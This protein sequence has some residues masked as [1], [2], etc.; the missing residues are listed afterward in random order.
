MNEKSYILKKLLAW[1]GNRIRRQIIPTHCDTYHNNH[2][3]AQGT[4]GA[5]EREGPFYIA[6][7]V[8]KVLTEDLTLELNFGG[9]PDR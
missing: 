4:V 9:R 1:W 8:R 5:P 3:S 7:G 2:Y 6:D